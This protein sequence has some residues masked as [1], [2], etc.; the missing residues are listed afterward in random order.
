MKKHIE[1]YI[2][3]HGLALTKLCLSL[4][5]NTHDAEDLCQS[6]WEKAIRNLR[7]Y[8]TDKPFEKWLFAICINT[9]RDRVR[10]YD[11]RK[12][13]RFSSDEEQDRFLS[14]IPSGDTDRDEMIALH[15][16]VRQLKPALREVIVLYYFRDYSVAEMS[17][18]LGIPEGTV[19]SRLST[20]R[21]QLRK[22]LKDD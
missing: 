8:D 18:I 22:E 15:T 1:T 2:A 9:Y 11:N 6:T 19:K 7:K 10:R 14:S 17:E 20:A 4:C 5:G 12:I 13:L 21:E 16:S 3:E